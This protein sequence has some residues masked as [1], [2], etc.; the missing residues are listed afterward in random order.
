MLV[1]PKV[2]VEDLEE[3]PPLIEATGPPT[4]LRIANEVSDIHRMEEA[5]STS[6]TE[7]NGIS[8]WSINHRPRCAKNVHTD[9]HWLNP[10]L[11][12]G[13]LHVSMILYALHCM[14]FRCTR[15]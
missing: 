9:M 12:E 14:Y 8:V 4:W 3:L 10:K 11:P 5:A 15:L 6:K 2:E 1:K 7:N 13:S